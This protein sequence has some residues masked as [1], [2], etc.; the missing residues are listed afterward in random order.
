MID[1]QR[2]EKDSI[3]KLLIQFSIPTIIA[4]MVNGI[5][6]VLDRIF[7]GNI[8]NTISEEGA[9][10]TIGVGIAM[11][12]MSAIGAF[13]TLIGTGAVANISIDLG[14]KNRVKAEKTL[15]NAL[16]LC[17]LFGLTIAILGLIFVEPMLH[18]FGASDKSMLYAKDYMQI[19]LL[20]TPFSILS[21]SFISLIRGD[22]NPKLSANIMI[23][24]FAVNTLLDVVFI[25]GLGFGIMGAALGSVL[26]QMLT[27]ILGIKYY[28]GKKSNL[29][30]LKQNLP[31]DT[32]IAF[33]IVALGA[34]PF[35]MQITASGVHA[36]TNNMLKAYGG[37]LAIGAMTTIGTI[38]M[39][40]G[41]PVTGL[42]Q[43][44]QP[45]IGYNFGAKNY[46][47]AEE[48]L[49]IS[50]LVSTLF[51]IFCWILLLIFPESIV[52]IFNPDSALVE[53]T[54]NGLVKYLAMLPIMGLA[55]L[56]TN[57]MQFIGRAKEAF[58]LILL[59]KIIL[60]LPLVLLL[61]YFFELDGI[62]LS[63]PITDVISVFITGYLLKK[64]INGYRNI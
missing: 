23:I 49:K 54:A 59:R 56:G 32:K 4:M 33:A 45:I 50:I 29:K 40:L 48:A 63:Q 9:L 34:S 61:P 26:G 10:A 28:L 25:F 60:L 47:R 31:L 30:F 5:Y 15:G 20:G 35:L 52:R 36:I 18:L 22:G 62:W 8:P 27:T 7:I 12:I 58:L 64:T 1:E 55:M 51:L 17:V 53:V 19:I 41:M 43:G 2:L 13:G 42:S 44:S 24:G 6:N 37:D 11:P 39:M 14:A 57:Y 38:L 46:A 3:V 21:A 16:S